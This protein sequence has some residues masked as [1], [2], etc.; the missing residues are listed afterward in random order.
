[1]SSIYCSNCGQLIPKSF[2]FCKYCGAAVHGRASSHYRAKAPVEDNTGPQLER[3]VATSGP[4]TKIR[5]Y[6]E[7]CNHERL[8]PRA[9]LLFFFNY[10]ASS[11]ILLLLFVIGAVLMPTVFIPAIA[12]YL[13]LLYVI[14]SVVYRNFHYSLSNVGLEKEHGVIHKKSVSVPYNQIQNINVSRSLFDRVLGIS[15]LSIETAGRSDTKARPIIGHQKSFAEAD[16]P[17]LT[18]SVAEELHD[19]LLEAARSP[20]TI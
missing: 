3:P 20:E 9:K 19:V 2:N 5:Q 14:A 12:A 11:S 18:F 4:K 16:L 6:I 7:N 8:C 10:L 15:R 17:G 13:L 1:M